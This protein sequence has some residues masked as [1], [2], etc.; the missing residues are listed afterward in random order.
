MK[1]KIILLIIT[2]IQSIFFPSIKK[3]SIDRRFPKFW[4]NEGATC[5]KVFVTKIDYYENLLYAD[6]VKVLYGN[7]YLSNNDER[8]IMITFGTDNNL[9]DEI[10]T[11]ILDYFLNKSFYCLSSYDSLRF[12]YSDYESIYFIENNKLTMEPY[13]DYLLKVANK[14]I[15]W[16]NLFYLE[17]ID[18]DINISEEKLV[19]R[20]Y[21]YLQSVKSTW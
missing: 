11:Q 18:N 21:S 8:T 17:I 3:R 13:F 15:E 6:V 9:H 1:I 5:L 14:K 19:H 12:K 2:L 7:K 4:Y 16:Q 20:F 10:K